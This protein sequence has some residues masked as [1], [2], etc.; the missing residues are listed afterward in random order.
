MG[1]EWVFGTAGGTVSIQQSPQENSRCL[2]LL[3]TSRTAETWAKRT[4]PGQNQQ[5]GIE[6]RVRFGQE[7]DGFALGVLGGD[8]PAVLLFTR[9]NELGCE[10]GNGEWRMLQRYNAN[11]WYSVRITLDMK[12]QTFSVYVD[13]VQRGDKLRFRNSMQSVDAWQAETP[14]RT[15]GT[16]YLNAIR[17]TER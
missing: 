9:G 12:A 2:R 17:V 7:A 8:K 6:C 13:G 11:A 14:V 5:V 16:L 10:V 15:T 1:D 4:F 3:D